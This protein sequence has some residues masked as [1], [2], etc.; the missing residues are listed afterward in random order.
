LT[1]IPP[2]SWQ[3]EHYLIYGIFYSF[4]YTLLETGDAIE[5]LENG[6]PPSSVLTT[7]N[8]PGLSND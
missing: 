5:S 2:Y 1:P 4:S 6:N 7:R 8:S 3:I